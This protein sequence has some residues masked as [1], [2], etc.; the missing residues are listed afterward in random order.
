MKCDRCG[1]EIHTMNHYYIPYRTREGYR[2]CLECAH[3][4]KIVTLV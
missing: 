4:E 3:K 2:L 1:K